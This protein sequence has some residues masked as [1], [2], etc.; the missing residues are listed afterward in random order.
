MDYSQVGFL[1][2]VEGE[3][4]NHLEISVIIPTLNEADNIERC[5][6]AIFAQS[7]K[8][9]EVIVI[10]GYSTDETVE[11]AKKF[12]VKIFHNEFIIRAGACQ[13]G[14]E[15]AEG[16]YIAF[17][18]ADCV[19]DPDWLQNLMKEFN[20]NAIIGLAGAT[21]HEIGQGLWP[22][23]INLALGTFIGSGDSVQ[24]RSYPTKRLIKSSS[25][26]NSIYRR[27]D[28]IEVGGFNVRLSGGE[29]ENLNKRL[30]TR[31]KILYVPDA[32]VWHYHKMTGL[33]QFSKR[34]RRYGRWKTEARVWALRAL[35]PSLIVPPLLL[36]L[37]FTPWIFAGA[38]CLYLVILLASA[39]KI[40]IEQKSAIYVISIPPVYA[41]GHTFFTI[42][43]W[44]ELILPYR[45]LRSWRESL[46]GHSK[47]LKLLLNSIA[48]LGKEK[49]Q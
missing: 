37:I 14:L 10:D 27:K 4:L 24:W 20:T 26:C 42:G 40:A 28:L 43:F 34:M 49:G 1:A 44:E 19:A 5:L 39:I 8:P 6:K 36:S 29:D 45:R 38:L 35:P 13:I 16:E 2:Q 46:K 21:K 23:A 18:D 25:G 33:R 7:H 9:D 15:N 17:T 32:V 22:Q 11:I 31:G 47:G 48:T 3:R 41:I 30:S 12:P